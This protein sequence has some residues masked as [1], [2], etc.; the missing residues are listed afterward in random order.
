[1]SVIAKPTSRRR[2][3]EEHLRELS[4]QLLNAQE[5]ERSRIGHELHEDLAQRLSVLSM[6]LS[7]FSRECDGNGNLAAELR[8]LQQHLRDVSKDVVRLSHQLRPATVAG[9]VLIHA[10]FM[11]LVLSLW[12]H[13]VA[14]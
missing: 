14:P 10:V 5:V 6:N 3:A 8:E 11:V 7:R 2:E 4:T 9:L 12:T 13:T 1:M